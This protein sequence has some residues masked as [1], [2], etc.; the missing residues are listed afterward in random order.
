MPKDEQAIAE[1][2]EEILALARKM[3]TEED[4][5]DYV[6]SIAIA[7]AELVELEKES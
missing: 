7:G 1:K 3:G 2:K 5:Y 4:G 6:N